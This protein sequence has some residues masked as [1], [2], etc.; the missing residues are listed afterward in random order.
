MPTLAARGPAC[1]NL[2][3]H[4][5]DGHPVTRTMLQEHVKALLLAVGGNG[6]KLSAHSLRHS[7]ATWLIRDGADIRTVQDLLG[8]ADISTTGRYLHSNET[9]RRAAVVRLGCEATA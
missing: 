9:G 6:R 7:F 5:R 8:H 2:L 3:A 4:E 1:D